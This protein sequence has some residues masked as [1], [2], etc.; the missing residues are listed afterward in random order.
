MNENAVLL[1]EDEALILLDVEAGLEEQGFAVVCAKNAK[2]AIEQFDKDPAAIKALVTD[3]RLGNGALG[4]EVARHLRQAVST[5]PVV[6]M[7]G[8]R[9]VDWHAEG[10]P[11]SVMIQKPFVLAQIITAVS[12]LLNEQPPVAADNNS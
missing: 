8:D 12:T 7:S 10:V 11:G 1:V 2:E 3:I 9:A 6:Y 4:W 5:M